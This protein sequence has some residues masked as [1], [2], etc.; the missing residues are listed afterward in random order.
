[1]ALPQA[2]TVGHQQ[3]GRN[4]LRRGELMVPTG[5]RHRTIA[6]LNLDHWPTHHNGAVIVSYSRI[7]KIQGKNT[8]NKTFL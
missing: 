3:N 1:M 2:G 7:P 5:I 6:H 4:P 8:D